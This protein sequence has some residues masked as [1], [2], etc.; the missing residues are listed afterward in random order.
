MARADLLLALSNHFL[1]GILSLANRV[2]VVE[3]QRQIAWHMKN[4]ST[5][6]RT[7][8]LGDVEGPLWGGGGAARAALDRVFGSQRRSEEWLSPR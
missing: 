1:E 7:A 8:E 4:S 6:D 2:S 3:A 5:G